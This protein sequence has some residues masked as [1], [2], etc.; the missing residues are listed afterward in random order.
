[1]IRRLAAWLVELLVAIDQL[2]HVLL[3]GPKFVLIGKGPCP[4]ADETISS[5]VG[6]QAIRG[7][8]WARIC[9]VPI[10]AFFRL[11]GERGHCR[12]RIEF[13]ELSAEL[14]AELEGLSKRHDN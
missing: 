14:R 12:R 7:R 8:R 3:G 13:E 5:K 11:L 10:D 6:R 9:E 4:S 1:V 2:L